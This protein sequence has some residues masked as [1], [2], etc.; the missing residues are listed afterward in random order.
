[1]QSAAGELEQDLDQEKEKANE[2]ERAR[3]ASSR[4]VGV[5]KIDLCNVWGNAATPAGLQTDGPPAA[6]T[7]PVVTYICRD[8]M[9]LVAKFSLIPSFS[10]H[11]FLCW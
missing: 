7:V 3:R 8:F 4:P 11:L 2:K 5:S 1:M 6:G 9:N 10:F